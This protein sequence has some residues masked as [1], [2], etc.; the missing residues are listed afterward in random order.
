MS[1]LSNQNSR[2]VIEFF[3]N[4]NLNDL[5]SIFETEEVSRI[6]KII[7]VTI[8][9]HSLFENTQSKIESELIEHI[10]TFLPNKKNNE[11]KLKKKL[12]LFI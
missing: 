12:G 4:Q 1:K 5:Y 6:K 7:N 9:L 3:L 8:L 10:K 11:E 2:T